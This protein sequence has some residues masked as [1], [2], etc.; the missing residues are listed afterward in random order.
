[1]QRVKPSLGGWSDQTF[2][3]YNQSLAESISAEV[4]ERYFP[5]FRGFLGEMQQRAAA[6]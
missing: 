6:T 4:I 3:T 1:M 2:H 5:L